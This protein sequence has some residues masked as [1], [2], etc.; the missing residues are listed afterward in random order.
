MKYYLKPKE[1]DAV[2]WHGGAEQARHIVDWICANG[3]DAQ[4]REAGTRA[5]N[6]AAPMAPI[7]TP[8]HISLETSGGP[9]SVR[10]HDY[11][12]RSERGVFTRSAPAPFEDA[13]FT[14]TPPTIE[15]L[16]IASFVGETILDTFEGVHVFSSS[17]SSTGSVS[18]E[19]EVDQ[20]AFSAKIDL[21][22][23][24]EDPV[25][26]SGRERKSPRMA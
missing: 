8:E 15:H 2:Q 4:Y 9:I 7:T 17:V 1:V 23:E 25:V 18:I 12:V 21:S 19:G 6:G 10:M 3:G 11:I 16:R 22:I 24:I 26:D 5:Y 14:M 13:H 20:N